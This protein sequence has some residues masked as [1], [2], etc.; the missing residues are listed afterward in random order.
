[1]SLKF[2]PLVIFLLLLIALALRLGHLRAGIYHIDEYI[3]MLAAQMTVLKG[4]PILPSGLLYH[5][6]LFLSYLAAPLIGLTGFTEEIARWP[7]VLAGMLTLAV[8]YRA[9]RQLSGSQ[10]AGLSA[11]ALATLDVGMI[12]WAARMRMYA[13]T[14]LLML[15]A[16]YFLL[17]GC[18]L[19]PRRAYRLAGLACFLGA[20]LAHSVAVVALPVWLLALFPCLWL[21]RSRFPIDWY[22]Q[23]SSWVELVGLGLV[24]LVGLGFTIGGQIPF[25]APESTGGG[26][27]GGVMGVLQ[28]FLDPGFSWQRIDDFVYYYTDSDYWPLPIL[29]GVAWLLAWV[30][31]LRGRFTRRDLATL[32]LGLIVLLTLAELGLALTSTWRKTR[33]LF[34]LCHP[35]MLLLAADGLA[36]VFDSMAVWLPFMTADRRPPTAKPSLPTPYSLLLTT[37][38][39]LPLLL[40]FL[41]W[42]PPALDVATAR[43]TGS[44]DTAF[45]WVEERWQEGDRVMTV[46]PSAAYLY[47]HRSDYYATQ[48]TARVLLDDESEELVDRYVGS[49]L[50]D[51]V[52]GLTKALTESKRLWFVVDSDRLYSRY[53]PLFVQQI[54]AQMNVMH[55]AGPVLVFL[56]QPY[57]RPLPAQPAVT[58]Q[59]NF[60]NLVELGGYSFDPGQVAPDGTMQLALY[61]RPLAAT[62]PKPYKIFVQLRDAHNQNVAQADHFIFE[63]YLN[64]GVL[65]Q[66]KEQG[67][68]LRDSADL[69]LPQTLPP[70]QYRLF[71]GLYDPATFERLPLLADTSGENAVLLQT[72]SV[73]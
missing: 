16:L 66:L 53:E 45:K 57:P 8:Y 4:A 51:S 54:F 42:T 11:L 64:P 19:R 25:L 70:G 9:A 67:E 1:M 71:V 62:L 7:S 29:A 55:Q 59:A 22:R 50:V 6:G 43:G 28:K 34:I 40:I 10:A 31:I 38:S 60:N 39:L 5:Q 46:H 13:L 63:G 24:V 14:V 61:W 18:L 21:G 44:Y 49:T 68:W 72:I 41:L 65:G 17:Q 23:K 32:F 27:G 33:Y 37:Y 69:S 3:S 47:L 52:E 58:L 30:A 73:P 48:G 20:I 36:R 2:R 12:L 35:A 15:L 26:G 56:S